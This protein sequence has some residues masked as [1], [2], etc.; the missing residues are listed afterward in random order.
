MAWAR[1]LKVS[2]TAMTIASTVSGIEYSS[3][4]VIR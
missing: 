4:P 2:M 1:R 3:D